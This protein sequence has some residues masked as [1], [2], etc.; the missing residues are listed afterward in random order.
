MGILGALIAA[1]IVGVV[2]QFLKAG[3]DSAGSNAGPRHPLQ[4][5]Q[6]GQQ[7]AEGTISSSSSKTHGHDKEEPPPQT[8]SESS[9]SQSL[10]PYPTAVTQE[11]ATIAIP[12]CRR[13]VARLQCET[14]VTLTESGWLSVLWSTSVV[15]PSGDEVKLSRSRLGAEEGGGRVKARLIARTPTKLVLEFDGVSSELSI[16]QALRIS[17]TRG[18]FVFYN[19]RP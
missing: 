16:I 11:G 8:I 13:E 12:R 14:Q 10:E 3:G 4:T 6:S 9:G 15:D 1:A 7:A 5:T 2:G 17:T 18:D 19:I